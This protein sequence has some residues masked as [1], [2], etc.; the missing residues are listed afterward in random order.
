MRIEGF[1][2]RGLWAVPSQMFPGHVE[3]EVAL[4]DNPNEPDCQITTYALFEQ[5][6]SPTLKQTVYAQ[7]LVAL[8]ALRN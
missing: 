1:I 7:I 6:D 4:F 5:I 8:Q 3:L 2:T